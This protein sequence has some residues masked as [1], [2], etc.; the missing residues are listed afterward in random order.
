[1]AKPNYSFEKRK[2]ELDRKRKKEEKQQRRQEK[3]TEVG[4]GMDADGNVVSSPVLQTPD[5]EQSG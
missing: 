2:K 5:Q 3:S 4:E 1:M